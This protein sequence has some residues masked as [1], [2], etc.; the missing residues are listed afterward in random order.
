[1]DKDYIIILPWSRVLRNG[2]MNPK[3]P[4]LNYWNKITKELKKYHLFIIQI[5]VDGEIKLEN[6]DECQFGIPLK[7]LKKLIL[8][9]KIWISVDNF[10]PHL[11]NLISK[12]G[13]V[14]WGQSD[15]RIFGYSN[16][17]NLFKFEKYFRHNQF[18]TWEECE[19]IADAFVEPDVVVQNVLKL[20][21]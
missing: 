2:K 21:K 3:N 1:M 5:G 11:A 10:L 8:N 14:I 7:E 20:L 19:Y 13:I 17:I 6:I 9:C 18:G 16:N 4:T 15:Y 12:Q